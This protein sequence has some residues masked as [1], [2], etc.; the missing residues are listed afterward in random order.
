MKKKSWR[1]HEDVISL[2]LQRTS[3]RFLQDVLIKTN[4][5]SS[6]MSSKCFHDV[7]KMSS[8]RLAK[9]SSSHLQNIL[10]KRLEDV[11]ELSSTC[12]AKKSS[13]H[14]QKVFKR[15]SKRLQDVSPNWTMF[16]KTSLISP[17]DV[18]NTF[19]RRNAKTIVYRKICIGYN[20]EKFMLRVQIFQ[21]WTLWIYQDFLSSFLKILYEVNVSANKDIL[22]K[23]GY[24]KRCCC[25]S[26]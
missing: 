15:S 20:S 23:V 26:K 9:T 13:R 22:I 17:K 1:H 19:L 12:L 14:F 2:R 7:F 24:Q 16:V 6:V 3:P 10:L 5:L 21:E 8:R 25:L 4:V 18:F 11:V